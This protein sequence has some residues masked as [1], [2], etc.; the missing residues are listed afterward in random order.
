MSTL[1]SGP[2]GT[3]LGGTSVG[4]TSGGR[5]CPGGDALVS[6][7][8][9]DF[10]PGASPTRDDLEAHV[11]VC[12]TCLAEFEA[13]GGVRAQLAA[14]TA[15]DVALGFEVVR[16]AA[17]AP[18]GW[19][20]TFAG[21]SARSARGL[22][23]AAAAIIVLGGAMALAR[24]D[25]RYDQSGLTVRTGWGHALPASGSG[26]ASNDAAALRQQLASLRDEI[27]RLGASQAATVNA[28]SAPLGGDPVGA[29]VAAT[30]VSTGSVAEGTITAAQGA[31]LLRS[32]RQA[33]DESELRQQQNLQLRIGEVTRDFDLQRRQDLVQVEQG[34]SRLDTQ[35]QQM[36][37]TIRRVSLGVPQQ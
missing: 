11:R 29:S 9:D 14:W 36:L 17:R 22:P 27:A 25:I 31:A 4:G 15:P 33:L 30:P 16:T 12:A 19:R 13:L 3:S 6:L 10:E 23:A 21:W 20:E 34:F 37:D 28:A 35:R 1:R 26:P 24:L 32:F 18:V 5:A 7:L 2:I 8:Y